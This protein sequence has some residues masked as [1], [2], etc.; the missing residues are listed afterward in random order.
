MF[1][2]SHLT[3]KF[4]LY[5]VFFCLFVFVFCFL[6]FYGRTRG[7]WRFPDSG[8][9]CSYSCQPTPEPQQCQIWIRAAS[10]NYTTA[11]GNAGSPTHWARR[12]GI[13]PAT[14]WLLVRFVNHW[15]MTGTRQLRALK[16]RRVHPRDTERTSGWWKVVLEMSEGDK[17]QTGL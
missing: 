5:K 3:L 17:H 12:P 11:H 15:A 7:I 9:N 4:N 13:E 6:S 16:R 1:G 10:V 8:L 14:S 2:R